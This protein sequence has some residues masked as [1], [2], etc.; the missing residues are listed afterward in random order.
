LPVSS[1]GSC[2]V[3]GGCV[4]AGA[5]LVCSSAIA[6][7]PPVGVEHPVTI[8]ASVTKRTI[9]ELVLTVL[10]RLV[11]NGDA[12][13]IIRATFPWY[14]FDEQPMHTYLTEATS[15]EVPKA[16]RSMKRNSKLPEGQAQPRGGRR[17]MDALRAWSSS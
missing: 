7:V 15:R 5:A 4:A 9:V 14:P 12:K 1:A 11:G 13:L 2:V 8:V 3:V 6:G 10:A 17:L 16:G